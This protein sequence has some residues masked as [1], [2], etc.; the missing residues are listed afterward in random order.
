MIARLTED[1]PGILAD[2]LLVMCRGATPTFVRPNRID[3]S[4]RLNEKETYNK[5][6]RA[7][8]LNLASRLGG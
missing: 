8:S 1:H 2:Y 5:G 4:G 7:K 3:T 6:F